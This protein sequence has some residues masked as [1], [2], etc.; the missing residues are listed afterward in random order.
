MSSL[1]TPNPSTGGTPQLPINEII[2]LPDNRI[3]ELLN[4]YVTKNISPAIYGIRFTWENVMNL[5]NVSHCHRCG[6]CC[7]ADP[8]DPTHPG[9]MV[10][11]R[12]LRAIARESRYSYKGLQKKAPISYDPTLPQRHYLPL[13]CMFHRKD[14]CQI[15]GTRP[16]ICTNYPISDAARE[17]GITVNVRCDYGREIY[18]TIVSNIRKGTLGE[19]IKD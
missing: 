17:N 9:V 8:H 13:P 6:K 2:T 1:P 7:I 16:F 12:D 11:E 5:L 15:Y 4:M 10:Y 18:W 3:T 14:R 19:I